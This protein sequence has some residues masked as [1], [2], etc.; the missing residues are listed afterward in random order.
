MPLLLLLLP[1]LL[2]LLLPLLLLLVLLLAPDDPPGATSLV[3]EPPQAVI[4]AASR[5]MTISG[6]NTLKMCT[7]LLRKL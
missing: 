7:P 2:E 1:L 6:R 5:G 4:P 3:P